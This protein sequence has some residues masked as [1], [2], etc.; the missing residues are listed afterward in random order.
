[1]TCQPS[2]WQSRGLS[3]KPHNLLEVSMGRQAVGCLGGEPSVLD[4]RISKPSCPGDS[5]WN[6]SLGLKDQFAHRIAE[7]KKYQ[8]LVQNHTGTKGGSEGNSNPF[9]STTRLLPARS[10]HHHILSLF[11]ASLPCSF[12]RPTWGSK[13]SLDFPALLPS[14]QLSKSFKTQ[15]K[16]HL[17][18]KTLKDIPSFNN[19]LAVLCSEIGCSFSISHISPCIRSLLSGSVSLVA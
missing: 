7:N 1:M 4:W 15:P 5:P 19:S 17:F 10:H 3:F 18:Q 9:H 14:L 11:L 2:K 8:P 6:L 12:R 13:H 16:S